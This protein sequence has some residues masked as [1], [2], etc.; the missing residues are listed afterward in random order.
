[1]GDKIGLDLVDYVSDYAKSL[2]ENTEIYKE[3]YFKAYGKYPPEPK[4]EDK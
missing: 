4:K 1:M 2:E 3:K